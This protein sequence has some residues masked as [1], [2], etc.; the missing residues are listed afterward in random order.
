MFRKQ[1]GR[2]AFYRFGIRR[3][4][5]AAK[6]AYYIA[7]LQQSQHFFPIVGMKH[8]TAQHFVQHFDVPKTGRRYNAGIS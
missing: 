8:E 2:Q 5:K 3:C 7:A 4:P 1:N 6:S